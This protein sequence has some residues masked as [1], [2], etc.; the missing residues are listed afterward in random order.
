[1]E[2]P[3][4][5]VLAALDTPSRGTGIYISGGVMAAPTVGAIL[6]DIL[7]YLGVERTSEGEP[8]DLDDLT[9]LTVK[10]AEAALKEKKLT[11]TPLGDGETI[12]GQLPAAGQSVLPGS[13]VL[14]YLGQPQGARM[15]TVPDFT[16][17]NRQQASQAAGALGLSVIALGSDEVSAGVTV[18]S[19]KEPAGSQLAAGSAVTLQFSDSAARD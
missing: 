10:E 4:Y 15:V 2:D 7:P 3:Q 12:T 14:V 9:G 13:E 6:A 8:V 5:I 1:M 19:Q 16:G 11:L 17:M 18:C